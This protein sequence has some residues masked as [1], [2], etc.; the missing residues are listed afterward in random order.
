MDE[1]IRRIKK[2]SLHKASSPVQIQAHLTNFCNL[3]CFFCPTRALLKKSELNKDKELDKEDWFRL[4]EESEELGV[5]E[6]HICGGGE[7]LFDQDL[8][9]NVLTKIKMEGFY[10][11]IITNGTLFT[12]RIIKDLVELGWDKI[13]FSIDGPDA[14]IHES[15]RG[16]ACFRKA[17][18]NIGLFSYYKKKLKKDRPRLSFHT[19]ICNKNFNHVSK[20]VNLAKRLDVQDVLF[21][22]LNIWSKEIKRLELNIQQYGDLKKSLMR[23]EKLAQKRGIGTNIGEFLKCD[24]FNKANR[25]VEAMKEEFGKE[26][27][28]S[29]APCYMPWYNMSIFADGRVQP[30]FILQD[31]GGS[32]KSKSLKEIWLGAYF[33][34]IR[35]AMI[36][37]RL[38]EVCSRCNPW[39][40]SKN[41]EIRNELRET[42]F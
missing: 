24:M 8:A 22:A 42:A 10:G 30:C 6:W 27:T 23:A 4:I 38:S 32:C 39:S 41:K 19:V 28:L 9:H 37:K 5:K 34:S 14:K 12:E 20:I 7:P 21:N 18:K 11:E 33:D 15:I 31:Q 36:E 17:V 2:W 40:F 1:K 25:V 16:V 26:N 13:T 29:D 35:R 3:Q